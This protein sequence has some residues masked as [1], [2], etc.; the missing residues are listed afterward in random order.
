MLQTLL[1][2][3]KEQGGDISRNLQAN[4]PCQMFNNGL[5]SYL[6]DAI[7]NF[8]LK[9]FK[10]E[11]ILTNGKKIPYFFTNR[12]EMSHTKTKGAGSVYNKLECLRNIFNATSP[13]E[14]EE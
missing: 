13:I 11:L 3:C 5:Q 2:N 4:L 10:A 9:I 14:C 7:R 8:E 6:K 1:H 12:F